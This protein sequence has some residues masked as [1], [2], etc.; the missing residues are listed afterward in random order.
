[1]ESPLAKLEKL[2]FNYGTG[3]YYSLSLPDEFL[4]LCN[5]SNVAILVEYALIKLGVH[6]TCVNSKMKCSVVHLNINI[7]E[8][9]ARYEN[10]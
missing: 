7:P 8:K 10:N 6:H 4:P 2:G 3:T 1:M 5:D 9:D